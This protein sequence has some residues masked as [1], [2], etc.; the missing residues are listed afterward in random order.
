MLFIEGG[1]E[2]QVFSRR[3][4]FVQAR[5]FEVHP[6]IFVEAVI[7]VL[8]LGA[9]H[10]YAAGVWDQKPRQNFLHRALSGA[11]RP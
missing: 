5:E 2:I 10:S 6:E 3:Q 4:L 7:A 1:K 11:G 9:A 8:D